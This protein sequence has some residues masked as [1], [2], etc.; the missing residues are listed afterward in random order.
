MTSGIYNIY[1]TREEF[2]Y[3]CI[4]YDS[5]KSV[6]YSISK[7]FNDL[8]AIR[9]HYLSLKYL[10]G[11][12]NYNY[13]NIVLNYICDFSFHRMSVDEINDAI[14]L[15]AEVCGNQ[16]HYRGMYS[17]Y[18]KY[19]YYS[20]NRNVIDLSAYIK[21]QYSLEKI[22]CNLGFRMQYE[23]PQ[24]N[25]FIDYHITCMSNE[26]YKCLIL[27]AIAKE[28]KDK[29][30]IR[31]ALLKE[32]KINALS[33]NKVLMTSEFF[34]HRYCVDTTDNQT[35]INEYKELIRMRRYTPK[36]GDISNLI[37]EFKFEN[38]QL[39]DMYSYMLTASTYTN[40]ILFSNK[41][42]ININLKYSNGGLHTSNDLQ[43]FASD[44]HFVIIEQDFSSFY[45]SICVNHN[46][47]NPYFTESLID[48]QK[49]LLEEKF[50][51]E[52]AGNQVSADL[53]KEMITAYTGMLNEE[54]SP[55]Y[56]PEHSFAMRINGQL[57]MSLLIDFYWKND[58]E[59]FAVNTD[60]I[61]IK[62]RRDKGYLLNDAR[63]MMKKFNLSLVDTAYESIFF[64][65]SNNYLAKTLDGKTKL[66]GF[67]D[68]H[69]SIDDNL[70]F[71]IIPIAIENYVFNNVPVAT[72]INNCNDILKFCSLNEVEYEFGVYYNGS[73]I[74]NVNR[75]FVAKQTKGFYLY[76]SRDGKSMNAVMKDTPIVVCNDD[77]IGA[78]IKE[79]PLDRSWYTKKAIARIDKLF[80][81][82]QSILF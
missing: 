75:I 9:S 34:I 38:K 6:Q 70:D 40:A 35:P 66:R 42:G 76:K 3:T 79:F 72:T 10:I 11:Y 36:S 47:N 8:E 19:K 12:N 17:K 54:N 28:S 30:N 50:S 82:Q 60:S 81:R 16:D 80:P 18:K 32:H 5:N 22:A 71:P 33:M 64:T 73:K 53:R 46:L 62:L 61:M 69:N 39:S 56:C 45:M 4:D 7:N 26:M 65:T 48:I 63:D 77:I 24:H 37:K 78:N 29:M 31:V 13:V 49:Q 1:C 27:K 15:C 52:R 14:F 55:F 51:F 41:N 67:Y 74:N 44:N 20:K 59:I 57:Y 58:V 2:I 68:Y 25:D 21:Y 43:R 23:N